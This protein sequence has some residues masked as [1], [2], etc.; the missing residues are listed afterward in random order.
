MKQTISLRDAIAQLVD[1][2][3]MLGADLR[4]VITQLLDIDLML[5]VDLLEIDLM[6]RVDLLDF[7]LMPRVGFCK[8]ISQIVVRLGKFPHILVKLRKFRLMRRCPL[9]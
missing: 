4:N 3:L 8:S 2:D 6:L 7:D 9:G 5:R 1:F